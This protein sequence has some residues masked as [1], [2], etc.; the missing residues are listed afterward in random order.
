MSK[1]REKLFC[2][3][4]ESNPRQFCCI[5]SVVACAGIEGRA[6]RLLSETMFSTGWPFGLGPDYCTFLISPDKYSLAIRHPV[7]IEGFLYQIL[8]FSSAK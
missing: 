6:C 7:F 1:K 8:H 4:W 3:W 2:R 5:S